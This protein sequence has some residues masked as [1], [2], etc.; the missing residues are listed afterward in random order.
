MF[1]WLLESPPPRVFHRRLGP[2]EQSMTSVAN[3]GFSMVIRNTDNGATD[4][5]CKGDEE[6][7]LKRREIERRH[8]YH[9]ICRSRPRGNRQRS[10]CTFPP[11]PILEDTSRII[12]NQWPGMRNR[13]RGLCPGKNSTENGFVTACTSCTTCRKDVWGYFLS[14]VNQHIWSDWEVWRQY[15]GY[16]L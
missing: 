14:R 16:A 15:K 5:K 11:R 7:R 1:L 4:K 2:C 10:L 13:P 6:H 3:Q 12:D 9:H 8:T